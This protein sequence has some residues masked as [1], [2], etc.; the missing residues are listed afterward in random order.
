A[1]TEGTTVKTGNAPEPALGPHWA[2]RELGLDAHADP[3]AAR[4]EFLRRLPEVEWVP[5]ATW[6]VAVEVLSG[7]AQPTSMTPAREGALHTHERQLREEVDAFTWRFFQM[8]P[9]KRRQ[10]WQ[11]LSVRCREYP[12]LAAWLG[13]LE[14]GLAVAEDLPQAPDRAGVLADALCE[15]FVLR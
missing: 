11:A 2:A 15:L 4:A 13:H 1:S 9:D 6:P 8:P 5:P 12:A 10:Q 3:A 7:W 14:T